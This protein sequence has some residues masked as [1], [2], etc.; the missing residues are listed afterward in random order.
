MRYMVV[1]SIQERY[2]EHSNLRTVLPVDEFL[3]P[4]ST[5]LHVPCR[6]CTPFPSRR[7]PILPESILHPWHNRW[8][9][10]AVENKDVS[11]VGID[12]SSDVSSSV[13]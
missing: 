9:V 1:T 5:I 8:L 13:W 7:I 6:K 4:N 10:V 11:S 12:V 3:R 2:Q